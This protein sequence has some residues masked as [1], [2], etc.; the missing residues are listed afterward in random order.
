ML[1]STKQAVKRFIEKTGYSVHRSKAVSPGHQ[2]VYPQATYAP[3][4]LDP[5]FLAAYEQV[6]RHTLV[7]KYRCWEL[8]KLVEQASRLDSGDCLEVGVWRGG[9]GCLIAKKVQLLKISSQV[10]LCDTFTGVVKAGQCDDAYKGGEHADTSEASVHAL[11][12]T[13]GVNVRVLRGM[14]PDDTGNQIEG[15]TLRF[16]HID[17]DVYQSAREST[18]WVWPRMVPRG[19]I[20]YDDYGFPGCDGVR[21]FLDEW[22]SATNC[23]FMHNLNGHAVIIK[24]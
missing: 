15:K 3:W 18:E 23:I 13:M 19:I 24:A 21:K 5:Q 12:H 6:R 14:F 4:L 7:D 16:C 10:Y 9:S 8:W 2:R 22:Q 1:W 17:V 20:V 11:A